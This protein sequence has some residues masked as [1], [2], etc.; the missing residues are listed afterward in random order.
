MIKDA[1]E[2]KKRKD[3]DLEENNSM[4]C[5]IDNDLNEFKTYWKDL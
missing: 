1:M 2:D 4:T 5:T 3:S